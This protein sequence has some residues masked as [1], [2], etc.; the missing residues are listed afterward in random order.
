LQQARP[1]VNWSGKLL[2][3]SHKGGISNAAEVTASAVNT[4]NRGQTG[5]ALIRVVPPTHVS[6]KPGA[7]IA[8]IW[9]RFFT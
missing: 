9:R 5:I 8:Q 7:I 6:V 2:D 3:H 1:R 4:A